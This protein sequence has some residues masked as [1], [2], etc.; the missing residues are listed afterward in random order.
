MRAFNI[1]GADKMLSNC[2]M[3]NA[4]RVS[5]SLPTACNYLNGACTRCLDVKFIFLSL[6][7]FCLYALI[8]QKV[9]LLYKLYAIQFAGRRRSLMD[10]QMLLF[11]RRPARLN[12][13]AIESSRSRFSAQFNRNR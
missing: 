2:P 5:L 8:K 12:S 6:N 1:H 13:A 4:N 11:T 9:S 10:G 7:Y 3:R